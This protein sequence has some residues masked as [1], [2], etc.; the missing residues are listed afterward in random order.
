VIPILVEA[1]KELK[2]LF[3]EFKAL[4]DAEHSELMKLKADNDNPRAAN[5]DEKAEIKNLKERLDAQSR[6]IEQLNATHH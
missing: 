2:S 5:D 4:L 1:L 6:D 3:D